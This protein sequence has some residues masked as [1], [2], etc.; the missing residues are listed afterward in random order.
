MM[1]FPGEDQRMTPGAPTEG[2][3]VTAG[4]QNLPPARS[5]EDPG[6]PGTADES[7]EGP[8]G[9]STR[10]VVRCGASPP[11]CAGP[12]TA[13]SPYHGRTPHNPDTASARVPQ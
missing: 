4:A 7:S 10:T 13:G 8:D 6:V 12:E 5:E 9:T 2:A 1:S 11:A 3:R